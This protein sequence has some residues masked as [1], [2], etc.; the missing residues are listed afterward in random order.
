MRSYQLKDLSESETKE[1]LQRPRIDFTSIFD[2]V[3]P[4][5][6]SVRE[7][8][9]EA[10]LEYTERFDRA[11][12]SP[13]VECVADMPEPELPADV[14]VCILLLPCCCFSC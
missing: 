3:R 5:V 9:D 4:I 12:P 14:K 13:L 1:L 6:D 2:A 7:R 11:Q 10:V 8:G